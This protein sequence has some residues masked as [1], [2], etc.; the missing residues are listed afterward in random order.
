[1]GQ[2]Q[3]VLNN[4]TSR[5]GTGSFFDHYLSRH[6]QHINLYIPETVN[7]SNEQKMGLYPFYG[8]NSF[9]VT[10]KRRKEDMALL[11]LPV[12]MITFVTLLFIPGKRE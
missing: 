4:G 12:S 1:M 7:N 9:E 5:M 11:A 8:T 2:L 6:T 3:T 10:D